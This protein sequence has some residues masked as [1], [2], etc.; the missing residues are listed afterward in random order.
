M[1]NRSYRPRMSFGE[2]IARLMYGRNG[3]DSLGRAM[4]ILAMTLAILNLFLRSLIVALLVNAAVLYAFFR[5][6]S[7]N[8]VKRRAENA[9]WWYFWKG[10]KVFFSL[11]KNKWRDRKT[12]IYHRCPHCKNT[13]R[14]PRVKGAHT[15]NCPCCH[16][17]FDMTVK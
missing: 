9:R 4:L 6:M 10:I 2:R 8:V 5:M 7:K 14:L 1:R 16:K 3:S 11:Q 13:L 12:H 17:R 15:V